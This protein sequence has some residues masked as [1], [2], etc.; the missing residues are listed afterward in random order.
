MNRRALSILSIV[1]VSVAVVAIA[2]PYLLGNFDVVPN[3]VHIWRLKIA[4][5][6]ANYLL[7]F[8]GVWITYFI[9][10]G[11][12]EQM[13][14]QDSLQSEL[15]PYL[16]CV[17]SCGLLAAGAAFDMS[18]GDKQ[19]RIFLVL[20]FCLCIPALYGVHE[21]IKKIRYKKDADRKPCA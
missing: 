10:K 6:V 8:L 1:I 2:I 5:T 9:S 16:Y 3:L 20:F 4:G 15:K 14:I 13:S 19:T 21:A 11:L 17:G 7:A 18:G 12:I